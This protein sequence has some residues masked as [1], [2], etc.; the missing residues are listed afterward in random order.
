MSQVKSQKRKISITILPSLDDTI[1]RI[2][3]SSGISK[4]SIIEIAIK[5]YI[6][7][8][9]EKDAKSLAKLTYDDLPTEDEWLEI[10]P[11]F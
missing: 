8:Q 3:E 11:K 10:Q 6:E 4:S 5:K 9:L 2:C 1:Q 7:D